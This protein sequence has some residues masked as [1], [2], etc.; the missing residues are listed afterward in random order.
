MKYGIDSLFIGGGI[1]KDELMEK[2]GIKEGKLKE[3][4]EKE[5][6]YPTYYT[7]YLSV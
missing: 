3:L 2:G 4:C 5:G 1:Y 7:E 6:C